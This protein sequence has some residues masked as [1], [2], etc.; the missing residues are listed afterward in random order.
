MGSTVA[1]QPGQDATPAPA[2]DVPA[3]VPG[4]VP[5]GVRVVSFNVR[6]ARAFDGLDSWPLRRARLAALVRSL[7]A[8][9]LGLQELYRCQER[10]LQRR[11]RRFESVSVGRNRRGG[12]ER[13]GILFDPAVLVPVRAGTRWFGPDPDRAGS[14]HPD[15]YVPRIVTA[16]VFESR[17]HG[18]RLGFA[19]VHFDDR[20]VEH[21]Q[22]GVNHL[23]AWLADDVPWVIVG[24]LNATVADPELAQ[25]FAAGYQSACG[26][27]EHGTTHGFGRNPGPTIDHVL[28][29]PDAVELL[30]ARVVRDR[31]GGRFASDHWPVVADVRPRG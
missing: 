21:R 22:D 2:V 7:D 4:S 11:L 30:G 24:D 27:D 17:V 16:A 3:D 1:Q 23:L 25:M 9:V 28:Y 10:Y 14:R 31:P 15:G 29:R 5:G 20:Q 13:C 6:N 18:W 26:D 12:G 19:N 8:D